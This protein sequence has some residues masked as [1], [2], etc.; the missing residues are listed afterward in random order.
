MTTLLTCRN[1]A[2][3][4]GSRRLL[5]QL[6]FALAMGEVVGIVG[7]NGAG[8][9]SLLAALAGLLH[10]AAGEVF[11]GD[12]PLQK[13]GRRAIAQRVGFLPQEVDDP[14][15]ATVLET[16]LIGRHPHIGFWRWESAADLAKARAALR[17]MGLADAAGRPVSTLS[18]GER[19]R[20]AIAALLTQAPRIYLL[21]EPLEALDLAYQARL[22]RLLRRLAG[23]TGIGILF[24][25]HDLSLAAR[26]ADR[27]ILLDGRGRTD[28]GPPEAT[29]RPD[30]LSEVYGC[31]IRQVEIAG[32]PPLYMVA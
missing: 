14:Y 13:L 27:V 16:A 5:E 15:P 21:D 6:D 10:P 12:A 18:G 25:L 2:V 20:L 26:H 31:R 32:E 8:K 9:S 23:L 7:P 17:R 29:L 24:S 19:Q 30:R 1:L 22:L 28:I 11:L 3:S 4:R